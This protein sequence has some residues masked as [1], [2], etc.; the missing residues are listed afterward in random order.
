MEGIA[1]TVFQVDDN[2]LLAPWDLERRTLAGSGGRLM[3]GGCQ[4]EDDIIARAGNAE[5]LWLSWTPEITRRVLRSLPHVRLAIRWGVGYEQIDVDG[6]TEEGVLVANC[7]TYG[8][9]DVAEHALLL[10]LMAA[11][12]AR[13]TQLE[14]ARGGWEEAMPTN[15]HRISGGTL[16]IVGLGRIGSALATRAAGLGLRLL[17]CDPFISEDT[18]RARGAEPVSMQTLLAQSD[19]V[20]AHVPLNPGTRHL[21]DRESFAAMKPGAIFVNT[22]RGPVA[23]EG[24]LLE[25][26]QN[27]HLAAAALDVFEV[28]PLPNDSPL[29]SMPQVVLTPHMASSTEEAVHDMR[30]EICQTTLEWARSG[31]TSAVVNP[32][33]RGRMREGVPP[34]AGRND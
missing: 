34:L 3:L 26:L 27:G 25:A 10:L 13:F 30:R 4:T 31:W 6:A 11:R 9:T 24:A 1:F 17:A 32:E 33:V 23:D 12:R 8:T 15:L 29:R 7:P 19:Y 18:V 21:F 22:C 14:M 20:S 2:D 5:V 28:E 16:G